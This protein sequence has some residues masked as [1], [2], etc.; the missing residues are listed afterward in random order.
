MSVWLEQAR[1]YPQRR[2]RDA[3]LP[4]DE[5]GAG[6]ARERRQRGRRGA[7]GQPRA[8]RRHA[9]HVRCRR[10]PA[11]DG[12]G[13][14]RPGV[15]R[16]RAARRQARRSTRCARS[17]A[18]TTMPTFG[19][20]PCTVPG[21]VDGWF[22]LLERWGTRSFAR[23]QRGRASRYAEDGFPLTRRGAWFFA[24]NARSARALRPA[25]LHATRTARQRPARGSRQPA[26]ARTL[27]V[28]ADDGPGAVLPR[29][30]RRGDRASGCRRRAAS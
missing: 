3:A 2:R 19:P 16:R 6:D 25:R 1:A 26:L 15:P 17:R 10:R 8:R 28:L 27:R 12:L 21:A 23:G 29:P 18:R 22:T 30:D 5:R 7:R 11:R 20:H 4:R 9:V 13:R 24:G 14:R